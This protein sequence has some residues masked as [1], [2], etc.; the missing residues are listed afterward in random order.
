MSLKI[1]G[2]SASLPAVII[3]FG[4]DAG[5]P[6]NNTKMVAKKVPLL[7]GEVPNEA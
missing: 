6:G 5:A 3:I 4:K 1:P 2:A 7:P